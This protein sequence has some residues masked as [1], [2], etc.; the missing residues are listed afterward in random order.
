MLFHLLLVT[1]VVNRMDVCH[2]RLIFGLS[3]IVK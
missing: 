3:M 2:S 1:C